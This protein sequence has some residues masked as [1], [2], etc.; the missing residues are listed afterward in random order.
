V[1]VFVDSSA[2]VLRYLR[3]PQ[4]P[5]VAGVMAA[6]PVW[7]ASAVART[8]V[9]QV[10]RQATSSDAE[11]VE[12]EERFRSDWAAFHV[13]PVDGRCLVRA[14]ELAALHR[15]L[16]IDGMHLAAA[17]RLPRPLTFVTLDAA[18]IPAA[19]ALGFEVQ[20]G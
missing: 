7:C 14:A 16:A 18:Q 8:E 2:L 19:L 11:R 4:T 9:G 3:S 10:L 13:V 12:L 17:D 1:T 20:P 6:D 5:S 15:V